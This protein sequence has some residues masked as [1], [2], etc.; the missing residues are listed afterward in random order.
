MK[1]LVNLKTMLISVMMVAVMGAT[2]MVFATEVTTGTN[3]TTDSVFDTNGTATTT[4]SEPVAVTSDDYNNAGTIPVDT[5]YTADTNTTTV[6]TNTTT[7]DTNT[8]SEGIN[9]TAA[10]NTVDEED[11]EKDE[12]PQTGIEDYHVG[13]LLIICVAA[14][15]YTYK[16]MKDYKNI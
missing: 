2:T 6:D 14:S 10:Y 3:T 8:T 7:I 9:E 12:M 11:N 5:N 13:A 16:K 4:T 15:I 1:K